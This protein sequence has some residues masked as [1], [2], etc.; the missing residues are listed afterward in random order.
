ML[1]ENCKNHRKLAFPDKQ[2][3]TATH[4]TR[5]ELRLT[6][7]QAVRPV[8][9]AVSQSPQSAQDILIGLQEL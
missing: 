8:W 2:L 6:H 4:V 7:E 9:A 5:H 1:G 3:Q